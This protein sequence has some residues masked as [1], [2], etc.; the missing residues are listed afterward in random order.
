LQLYTN[1][2]DLSISLSGK[3]RYE[4]AV[5]TRYEEPSNPEGSTKNDDGDLVE[6][7]IVPNDKPVKVKS[8]AVLEKGRRYVIEASGA[9]S[10]WS[11]KKDGVDAVWG[12]AEW[13]YGK[14]GQIVNL[15]RID[16]KG[17]SEI[18]DKPLPYNS[19]HIYQVRYEGQGKQIEVY[20]T[21]AQNSWTDNSGSLTVKIYRDKD[22]KIPIKNSSGS[23]D[24]SKGS[25]TYED[26]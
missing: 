26:N 24:K 7:L 6:T 3:G 20:S 12:Y 25:V 4:P 23:W 17:M 21:D 13:R 1:D 15:L 9:V 11:H 19:Q 10:V 5:W 18:A 8:T 2:K 22:V 14:K 16:G